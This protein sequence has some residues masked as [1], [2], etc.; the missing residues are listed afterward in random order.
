MLKVRQFCPS[1]EF[2]VAE[3]HELGLNQTG[4]HLGPGPWDDDLR[5]VPGVYLKAG[6]DFLIGVFDG[7]TVAMGGIRRVSE[8]EAEIKR[9]RVHPEYQRRGFGQRILT[10]L[11]ARA[12]A[13]GYTR[14]VLDTTSKQDAAR[15]LYQ[16]NG[17][18][19]VCRK[20]WRDAEIVHYAKSLALADP[21]SSTGF[22]G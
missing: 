17:Y 18:V 12:R 7:R 15:A 19:E 16:K 6:G 22:D 21:S 10:S 8:T 14:L 3:L 1:D 11:E 5:D 9:M 4:T 13:L 20:P 2:T